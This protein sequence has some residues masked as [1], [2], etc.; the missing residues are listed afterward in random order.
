MNERTAATTAGMVVVYF[1]RLGGRLREDQKVMLAADAQA[2]ARLKSYCFGGEHRAAAH[3][4][5]PVYFVPDDT[6]LSD[7]AS[8]L[9]VTCPDDLY[10][11]VVPYP[12]VKTKAITHPLVSDAASRPAGWSDLFP[13]SVADVVL[14]GYTAFSPADARI[15]ARRLLGRGAIRLKKPLGASGKGQTAVTTMAELDSFLERFPADEMAT[16]GLVLEE[17][18]RE[19]ET[20]SV[21]HT[22]LGGFTVSYHGTQRLVKDN[23]G[24]SVYGGSDL[25]CARGGWDALEQLA[26]LPHVRAAVD[27]ARTYDEAMRAYPGFMASR[28]NYDVGRGIDADGRRRF[29]V[30]ESSWRAGG[31]SSAELLASAAFARDPDIKVVAASHVEQFGSNQEPPP[32]A[33]VHFHGEAEAGPVLRYSVV[34]GAQAE[35]DI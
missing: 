5:G 24:Q 6:L 30:F 13:E 17:N 16:Y 7:E 20:F 19:V 33:V 11:G 4:P 15:A 10:G 1:S 14:P 8:C 2:I 18:L 31:A 23:N 32:D 12:F 21:G 27:A 9:G 22:T 29:G 26:L 25:V 34:T 35:S 28:R 3:Y